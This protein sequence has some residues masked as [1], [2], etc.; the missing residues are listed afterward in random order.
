MKGFKVHMKKLGK[1]MKYNFKNKVAMIT[2]AGSG[3]GQATSILLARY[4]CN[5]CL[6]DLNAENLKQTCKLIDHSVEILSEI[7]D[8][9]D[10]V[11]M[12]NCIKNIR[13]KFQRL[14][15]AFN[16]AGM[17]APTK[18]LIELDFET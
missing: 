14:D 9:T 12:Q 4:G 13:Q 16:N 10:T 8:V 3:I 17:A 6:V 15:F 18:S 1:C 2:G 5:L 11:F 7:G